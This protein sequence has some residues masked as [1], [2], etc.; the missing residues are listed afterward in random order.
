MS[1]LYALIFEWKS[2]YRNLVGKPEIKIMTGRALVL[3]GDNIKAGL[4][5]V[6]WE[7]VNLF[8][9]GTY[10]GILLTWTFTK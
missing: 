4:K 5:E 8:R 2:A 10:G 6:G 1:E 3:V 9:R 7:S